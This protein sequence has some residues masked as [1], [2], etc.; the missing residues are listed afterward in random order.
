M[1]STIS[2]PNVYDG[3]TPTPV[4]GG[5]VTLGK[6]TGAQSNLSQTFVEAPLINNASTA[7]ILTST[8][9]ALRAIKVSGVITAE[10]FA[11]LNT[12]KNNIEAF[13]DGSQLAVTTLVIDAEGTEIFNGTGILTGFTWKY[14]VDSRAVMDYSLEFIEGTMGGG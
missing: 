5:D 14:S 3:T 2:N 9:G 10:S 4:L 6:V 12:A 7:T 11:L 1:A 8:S 13:V